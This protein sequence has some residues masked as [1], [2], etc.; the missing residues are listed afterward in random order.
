[1]FQKNF[2]SHQD[3]LIDGDFFSAIKQESQQRLDTEKQMVRAKRRLLMKIL[4]S[5]N[6]EGSHNVN[7][8]PS[9]ISPTMYILQQSEE[10]VAGPSNSSTASALS[11]PQTHGG[12]S[13]DQPAIPQFFQEMGYGAW[14][15]RVVGSIREVLD[16]LGTVNDV[17]LMTEEVRT[18]LGEEGADDLAQHLLDTESDLTVAG[19]VHRCLWH[20]VACGLWRQ[21]GDTWRR[22]EL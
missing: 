15:D 21:V 20:G 1:M 14:R 11:H 22:L 12:G 10:P 17:T 3:K 7:G 5:S 6:S 16:R 9:T 2:T 4:I 13:N 8:A 18:T 19:F